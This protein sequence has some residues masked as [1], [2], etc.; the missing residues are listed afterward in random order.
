MVSI[1]LALQCILQYRLT[2]IFSIKC[3]FRDNLKIDVTKN[4]IFLGISWVKLKSEI[5]SPGNFFLALYDSLSKT[6][7]V[8]VMGDFN[9]NLKNSLGERGHYAPN[10]RGV[11]LLDFANYFNLCPTNLLST[12]RGPLETFVSHCGRFKSTID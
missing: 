7:F 10:D 2:N 4:R 12:C 8:I 11:K 6:V 9:G 5:H 3:Y 1:A